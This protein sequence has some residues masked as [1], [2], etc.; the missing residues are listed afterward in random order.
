MFEKWR[1]EVETS[2]Y[3]WMLSDDGDGNPLSWRDWG[4]GFN[5]IPEEDTVLFESMVN[6]GKQYLLFN[7]V[8]DTCDNGHKFA[9]L[10]DHPQRD[11]RPRCPHCLAIFFD[12]HRTHQQHKEN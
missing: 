12:N 4:R 2:I 7:P 1:S 8:I 9:K 6:L 3:Q 10:S 5:G 11:G